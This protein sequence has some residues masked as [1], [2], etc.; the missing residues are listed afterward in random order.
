MIELSKKLS[1]AELVGRISFHG[2]IITAIT[3]GPK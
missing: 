3:K 2:G 1:V